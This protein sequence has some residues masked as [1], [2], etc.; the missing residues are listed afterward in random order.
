MKQSLRYKYPLLHQLFTFLVNRS[1]LQNTLPKLPS[2]QQDSLGTGKRSREQSAGVSVPVAKDRASWLL[3]VSRLC[4]SWDGDGPAMPRPRHATRWSSIA[5]RL[6][7]P[8]RLPSRS[9]VGDGLR[10]HWQ[11]GISEVQHWQRTPS[12]TTVE[13]ILPSC[14]HADVM[15]CA[16]GREG[17][18]CLTPF[19][20]WISRPVLSHQLKYKRKLQ[21]QPLLCVHEGTQEP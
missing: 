15:P 20:M 16:L 10:L 9:P 13:T 8:V 19:L 18:Q 17:P 7:V 12:P 5:R 11:K 3:Q 21:H 6:H 14:M 2:S 1:L 4:S